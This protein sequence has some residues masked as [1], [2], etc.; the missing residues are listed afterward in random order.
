MKILK[1]KKKKNGQYELM[2]ESGEEL[3][4]YEDV[5]LNFDLLLKK[6]IDEEDQENIFQMN[7]EYDVYY[8]ALKSLK[9]R[10]KSVKE[11]KD[12]LLKKQYPF[13][14]VDKAIAKLLNQGYL[15]DTS[16]AKAYI[17]QQMVTTSKGPL[18]IERELLDKGLSSDII[19]R[20]LTVFSKEEQL[21]KIEK[22]ASRLIKSN[23]S[24]GGMVLRK[25]I[26]HDLQTLGYDVSV[27]EEGLG[28][29]EFT[30]TK[31]IQNREYDKLYRRLS[32]KYS[33]RELEYK[34][35]EKLYQKGL[36]YED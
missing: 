7:Q 2:L 16:F 10:F 17:N 32:K 28:N 11:L 5:I 4:L 33:G 29:V 25:K 26:I 1:Y 21:V 15:D 6:T 13:E 34:I 30:D 9:T 36:Y 22:V 18:K 27:I 24:R 35:K 8:V 31:D 14:Y 19:Y 23:R 20:E 3:S 12:L